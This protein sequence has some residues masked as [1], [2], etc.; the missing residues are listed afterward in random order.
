M[1][2]FN[3]VRNFAHDRCAH[4]SPSGRRCSQ[5][6]CS[7]DPNYCF[8][9][10]PK[11]APEP[12]A[13]QALAAEL[14]A[15][16]GNL[17]SPEDVNRVLC[18]VF[19]A[20][21]QDR[22]TPRKASV[23]GYL[24]QMILRSHREIAN[25]R[26]LEQQLNP[27]T[28]TGYIDVPQADRSDPADQLPPIPTPPPQINSPVPQLQS[29]P[30]AVA[31]QASSIEL[32]STHPHANAQPHQTPPT[33]PMRRPAPRPE[34]QYLQGNVSAP[35]SFS[36]TPVPVATTLPASS[37]PVHSSSASPLA[38]KRN[39]SPAPSANITPP[40]PTPDYR[41]FYHWDPTLPPGSQDPWSNVPPEYRPGSR[42]FAHRNRR[43]ARLIE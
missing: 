34:A 12:A 16:A 15:A 8:V 22:I 2:L 3:S 33:N 23:L 43:R 13:D 10:I 5:P 18:K 30:N 25:N 26:K 17:D 14:A 6:V 19:L 9:H 24:G 42:H 37:S 4:L 32:D 40:P 21:T 35:N 1:N 27:P 29:A 28:M 38:Q 36:A 11:P 41:H 39:S 20:V 31:I 7:S